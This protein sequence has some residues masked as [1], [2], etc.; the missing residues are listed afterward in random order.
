MHTT[1]IALPQVI[2]RAKSMTAM[3]PEETNSLL[4]ENY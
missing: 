3:M 1:C 2:N 4:M